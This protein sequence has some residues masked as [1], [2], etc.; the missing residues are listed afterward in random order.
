MRIGTRPRTLFPTLCLVLI[1]FSAAAG[2]GL[3]TEGVE[4]S[5][6]LLLSINSQT[7]KGA[8]SPISPNLSLALP[9][10]FSPE[11]RMLFVPSLSFYRAWYL[12]DTGSG[13]AIPAE[14]EQRDVT[15]LVLLPDFAFR[16]ESIIRE[17]LVSGPELSLAFFAPVPVAQMSGGDELSSIMTDLYGS[18]KFVMPGFGWHLMM[19]L[20]DTHPLLFTLKSYLPLHRLW[21][22][23]GLPVYDRLGIVLR[24]G[25]RF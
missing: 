1:L 2:Y 11:S 23:A 7:E 5:G 20:N 16:F 24:I 18:A 6:G 9:L 8:P 15:M 13:T 22:G 17:N 3:E 12:Y 10:R 25:Y 19:L 14:L 21:D 4:L